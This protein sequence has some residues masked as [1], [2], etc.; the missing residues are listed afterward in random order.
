MQ[1][2]ESHPNGYRFQFS[3][4][5][6]TFNRPH[7]LKAC[8]SSISRLNYSRDHFEVIVIDDGKL[9]NFS[10]S[11]S[12]TSFFLD[13]SLKF[14]IL[15]RTGKYAGNKYPIDEPALFHGYQFRSHLLSF[16]KCFRSNDG[17]CSRL[18][19]LAVMRKTLIYKAGE[20]INP[21]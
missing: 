4:I 3:V 8:L 17:I 1:Q 20:R 11:H 18:H 7:W 12:H 14:S 6:P 16:L 10:Q 15:K 5:I 2:T 21:P 9:N 19:Q 13:R